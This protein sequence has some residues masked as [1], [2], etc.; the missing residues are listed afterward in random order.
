MSTEQN[1][2][3]LDNNVDEDLSA[4]LNLAI[5]SKIKSN[6]PLQ[7]IK[8][9]LL[10]NIL[11]GVA[12]CCGYIWVLTTF[13]IWQVR[14]CLGVVM[15]FSLW[16]IITAFFQYRNINTN[17]FAGNSVLSELKIQQASIVNWAKTQAKV[18]LFIY[19]ISAAGGFMLGGVVGSGKSVATLLTKPAFSIA[20]AIVVIILTPA[21]HYLAKWMCKVAFG[22]HL[23]TLKQNIAELEAEK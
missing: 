17:V 10:Y 11:F 6:N 12:I 15:A 9:N 22:K 13:P 20:F 3:Q 16:A 5:I 4:L 21:C 8:T 7:K 19:P 2:K 14:L 18:A 23:E 1:W